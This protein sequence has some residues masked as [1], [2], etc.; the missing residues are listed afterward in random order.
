MASI[1]Q[2]LEDANAAEAA[3]RALLTA[4]LKSERFGNA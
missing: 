2:E 4:T 1:N 3:I